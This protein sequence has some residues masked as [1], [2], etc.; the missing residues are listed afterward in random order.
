[1]QV[2]PQSTEPGPHAALQMPLM[3]ARPVPHAWPHEPQFAGSLPSEAHFWTTPD[4]TKFQTTVPSAMPLPVPA[5]PD[6]EV[7]DVPAVT[8]T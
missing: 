4:W 7:A 8:T 2:P 5:G 1:M 6:P 3:Q